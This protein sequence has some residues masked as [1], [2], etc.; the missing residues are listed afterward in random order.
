MLF[1]DRKRLIFAP[2]NLFLFLTE[3]DFFVGLLKMFLQVKCTIQFNEKN[4]DIDISHIDKLLKSN[5]NFRYGAQRRYV[6][7]I[8]MS[9]T[10]VKELYRTLQVFRKID[11]TC[12]IH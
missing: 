7:V 11:W 6:H 1:L 3:S 8:N 10:D 9:F 2:K 5:I 12:K 4:V